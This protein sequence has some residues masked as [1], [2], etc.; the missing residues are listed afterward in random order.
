M[1]LTQMRLQRWMEMRQ[2]DL[3]EM[4]QI[5]MNRCQLQDEMSHADEMKK[6]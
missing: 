4:A 5:G 3:D 6:R 2:D 1:T